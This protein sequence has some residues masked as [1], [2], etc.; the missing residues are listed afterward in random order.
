MRTRFFENLMKR[1]SRVYIF[2][3]RMGGYLLGLI[4]LM[5]LLAIGY[6]NN[7]LLIFTIF[8]FGLNL[9]WLAG[10]HFHLAR[11]TPGQVLVEDGHALDPVGVFLRWKRWP[12]G[13]R[14]W[15]FTL[16]GEGVRLKISGLRD[17]EGRTLGEVVL[18]S[19][20]IFKW[21][22]L[23]AESDRP[24]GLY[25]T[26]IYFPV[27]ASAHAYPALQKES[28]L[29]PTEIELREGSIVGDR[30][31]DDGLRGLSRYQGEG[32]RRISWK[33]YAKSGELLVK[34]GEE[35]R[36]ELLRLKPRL[37]EEP[38]RREVE[39][40][41]MATLMVSCYRQEIPFIYEAEVPLGPG[42]S[43]DHL[44]ECLRELARV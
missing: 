39:L 33:H 7:L 5:F 26:W 21:S 41:R 6:S 9:L 28:P 1:R 22:H 34:E 43:L 13:E 37:P 36:T 23:L 17:E 11:L 35:L 42:S 38:K 16:V 31:G 3:T 40:S 8:L 12:R 2:P 27:T 29:P 44:R 14:Q 30:K 32:L 10:S 18:P 4:A 15:G 24:F 19:R 25:R 20:G